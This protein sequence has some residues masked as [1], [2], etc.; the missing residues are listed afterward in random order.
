MNP[1][2]LLSQP[3]LPWRRGCGRIDPKGRVALV[4]GA[5]QGIGLATAES[6]VARGA[7]VVLVDVDTDR[8]EQA[9]AALGAPVAHGV[10]ADVRDRDAMAEAAAEA[11]RRF[12][13]I[14]VVVA[15]AGITPPPA[16]LRDTDLDD[17]D[18]VIAINL[19]GVVNTVKPA[20]EQVIEHQGHI[21]M[22]ASVAAFAPVFGGASYVAS[23]AGV[24]Q[25]GRALR[26][27]LGSTGATAGVAYFGSVDTALVK[28]AFDDDPLGH[29]VDMLMPAPIRRRITPSRAAEV[30]VDGVVNRSAR[31]IAPLAWEPYS[32]FRELVNRP[33][34]SLFRV[35][36]RVQDIVRALEQRNRATR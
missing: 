7:R 17:F 36:P 26:I 1:L 14:D 8:L 13:R 22:V 12:G 23:K 19:T 35:D 24:E 33:L 32:L 5:A 20:L 27:E 2:S 9:V 18:R 25:L 4:T 11:V 6:L 3:V 21:V 15:N 30:L 16:T 10:T 34:V 28:E 29:R 31:T